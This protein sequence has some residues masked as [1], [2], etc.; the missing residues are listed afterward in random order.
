MTSYIN[1]TIATSIPFIFYFLSI[2]PQLD[3]KL[4]ENLS[5]GHGIDATD[6]ENRIKDTIR[7]ISLEEKKNYILHTKEKRKST[8]WTKY[9]DDSFQANVC[10]KIPTN[11]PLSIFGGVDF[12]RST[13]TMQSSYGK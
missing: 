9:T 6:P 3:V 1:Y 5:L 2:E 11:S 4:F 13:T 7:K 10:A 12:K 8:V